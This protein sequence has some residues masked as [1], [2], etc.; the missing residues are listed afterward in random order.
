M[1]KTKLK[2]L[3]T[4]VIV[5]LAVFVFNMNTVNAESQNL[6]NDVPNTLEVGI[7]TTEAVSE[8]EAS[9]KLINSIK[10]LITTNITD[11]ELVVYFEYSNNLNDLS[12]VTVSL[13]K[14]QKKVEEKSIE[15]KYTDNWNITDKQYV[16]NKFKT[17]KL[18]GIT[19]D[20]N[21][22]FE[23][24][25]KTVSE[26]YSKLANDNSMKFNYEIAQGD[27]GFTEGRLTISK[28]NVIYYVAYT[29]TI[30]KIG[31]AHV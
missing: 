26:E 10:K 19:L 7:T 31:R 13:Y 6:L 2:V 24:I 28:N 15:V 29:D 22:T 8:G 14:G 16:E 21:A 9:E 20:Y 27:I 25:N 30:K 1:L 3:V 23:E 12:K 17:L 18:E 4:L 5:L 11:Y